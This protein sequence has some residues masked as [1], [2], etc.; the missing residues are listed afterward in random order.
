MILDS[1]FRV[2]EYDADVGWQFGCSYRLLQE[3]GNL[4]GAN[5]LWIA[6]TA[7]RHAL[8]VVTRNTSDFERVEGLRVVDY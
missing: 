4:I 1:T 3:S 6:A 2:L 5:D 8:P 7:L